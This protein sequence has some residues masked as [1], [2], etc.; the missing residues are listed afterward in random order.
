MLLD[1]NITEKSFGDKSLMK[2]IHFGV[3]NGE[4]I[5]V[6]GRNG[7]GKST[8]LKIIIGED[9]D[10]TGDVL[11]KKGATVVAT[12]QEYAD[13]KDK[14]VIEYILSGLPEYVKLS[15]I[16]N[17]YPHR[18]AA[19]FTAESLKLPVYELEYHGKKIALVQAGVGGPVAAAQIE[20][21]TTLGCKKFIACGSCGVLDKDIAAGH[22]II[23]TSSV[24]DEGT[25]YHYIAP[26]REIAADEQM[27]QVIEKTFIQKNVP[28]IK[29]KTWTTDAIYRE[30]PQRIAA[31]K[32]EGCVTVEMEAAAYM[33]VS[34]FNNVGF[35]QI[36]YAGDNLGGDVWDS[37]GYSLLTDIREF[38]LRH[39]LDVCLN[40]KD[41]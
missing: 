28:Y 23:P 9:T 6:I 38:V 10:Y 3:N 37:R 15:K 30:T 1:V 13:A 29:A 40:L 5:G 14:T 7:A 8:L 18:V 35:G 26:S 11:L 16:I 31:R 41:N 36:L 25:S 17:E 19:D 20:E 24:R 33:A 32:N 27:I 12:S 21:L 22:L 2:D 39:A 4:K 34:Q